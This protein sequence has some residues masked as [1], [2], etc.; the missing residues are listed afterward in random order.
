[1]QWFNRLRLRV[2]SLIRREEVD[3]ELS[4]ELRFHLE[5]QV[6]ENIAHGMSR[7][8]ARYAAMRAVGGMAQIEEECRD[9][10][11]VNPIETSLQDLKYAVRALRKTP[12][13]TL[14]AVLSLA[15]GIGANTAVFSIVYPVLARAL[16]YPEANRLVQV[17]RRAPQ[18]GASLNEFIFF[19]QNAQSF[20][21]L[22]VYEG[23]GDQTLTADGNVEW[24]RMLGVSSGFFESLGVAPMM[25]RE[26]GPDE[27]RVGGV[28]RSIVIS[29]ALWKQAF[30]GD[31]SVI[32]KRATIGGNGYTI[33]GVLPEGFWFP[34]RADVYVPRHLSGT[35]GD[36]G[37]NAFAIAR[38]RVGVSIK[39]ADEEMLSLTE[40]YKRAYPDKAGPP[41]AGFGAS[42]FQQS[43]TGE[44]RTTL[45]LLF[46]AVGLLLVIA[47]TNLAGLLFAR[48]SARQREIAVRLALGSS[49]GRLLRLFMI[50][51]AAI[52]ATGGALGLMGAYLSLDAFVH[53]FPLEL[54]VQ[55]IAVNA[56]VLAFTFLVMLAT[57]LI[58]SVA[59]VMT[60]AKVKVDEALK[61]GRFSAGGIRQKA[62]SFLVT[63]EVA[64][65]TA[66]LIA[67]SLLIGSLYRLHQEKL[68]FVPQGL[69]TFWTPPAKERAGDAEKLRQFETAL[70]ERIRAVA[71]VHQVA[72][73]NVLPLDGKNNYPAQRVGHPENSEGGMEIRYVTPDYFETMGIPILRGRTLSDTDLPNSPPVIAIN[74]TVAKAW[75]AGGDPLGD[76]IAT[77]LFRGRALSDSIVP[78]EVVAVV[79]D[80]KSAAL[81]GKAR[82]TIYIPIA[83]SKDIDGGMSWVVRASL[84]PDLTG[85][86]KRAVADVDPRQRVTEVR[87]ME[88]IVSA[89]MTDSRFD[90]WIFGGFAGVAL[91]LTAIGEY[92]LLAFFVAQR[93]S[94]IGVRVA[95]GATRMGIAGLV[96]K[97]GLRLMLVGVTI[98]LAGAYGLTRS[99]EQL[100]YGVKANDPPSFIAVPVMLLA[101]G[102]LAS[103]FPGRRAMRV[104]PIT[105]LR[106]E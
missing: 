88:E 50:E 60:S 82:P 63:M 48:L 78:R 47:C 16:P 101:V 19:K 57:S 81:K 39:Q 54:P 6:E 79:G 46:G 69:I 5:Q 52:V 93:T 62:R 59:P 36:D 15:L 104:D 95:L 17:G 80:T 70:R 100:L 23:E 51:N 89:T 4:A 77:G 3:G 14:V 86:L 66:L 55:K 65:S 56:E 33:V 13:F 106:Y 45:L 96:L 38:L 83:Q 68:G 25:G 34:T 37:R 99:F 12:G 44:V 98:G 7:E 30:G 8:E 22:A 49:A 27:M 35:P 103:Y 10:R 29:H 67:A 42:G 2:R 1:M 87:T 26:F 90:A 53:L 74:E 105:A 92:G 94:E 72:A 41:F 73:V 32:G 20:S 40:A 21:S 84:T 85:Q 102:L 28:A 75:W 24:V 76:R 9:E 97:Q 43:L 64:M 31:A 91:L 61:S 58:L 18:E 11:R 71:G